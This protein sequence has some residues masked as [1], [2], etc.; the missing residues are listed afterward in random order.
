MAQSQLRESVLQPAGGADL[1][2]V[3]GPP[4]PKRG[5][6]ASERARASKR[7]R[8]QERVTDRLRHMTEGYGERE[9]DQTDRDKERQRETHRQRASERDTQTEREGE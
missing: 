1:T 3:C 9:R 5:M 8:A 2:H 7:E 6:S 4:S